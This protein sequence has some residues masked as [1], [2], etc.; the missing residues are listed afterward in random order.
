MND[1]IRMLNNGKLDDI[2]RD[3]ASTTATSIEDFAKTFEQVYNLN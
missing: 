3:D 2:K 1:Y